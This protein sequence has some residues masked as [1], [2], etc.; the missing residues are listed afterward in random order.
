MKA[1][2]VENY[3]DPASLGD[4]SIDRLAVTNRSISKQIER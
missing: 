3:V 4:R 1:C 2:K